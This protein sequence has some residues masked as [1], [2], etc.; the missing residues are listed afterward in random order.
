MYVAASVLSGPSLA[1]F[2]SFIQVCLG[3]TARSAAFPFRPPSH[4]PP[5]LDRLEPARASLSALKDWG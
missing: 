1:A 3:D 5:Y 2:I 4:P